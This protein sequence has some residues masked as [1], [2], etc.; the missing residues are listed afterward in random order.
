MKRLMPAKLKAFVSFP[1][2]RVDVEQAVVGFT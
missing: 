2:Y 1:A